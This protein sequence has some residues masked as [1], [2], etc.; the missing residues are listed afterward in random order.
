M[1]CLSPHIADISRVHVRSEF[2][3]TTLQGLPSGQIL[4][5]LKH[6]I[7]DRR[8]V[9]EANFA[10][11]SIVHAVDCNICRM[12]DSATRRDRFLPPKLQL[13]PGLKLR[14]FVEYVQREI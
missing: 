6:H 1:E 5:I 14:V 12:V 4:K 13:V 9:S 11:Q 8:H 2:E 10:H 7:G 3:T